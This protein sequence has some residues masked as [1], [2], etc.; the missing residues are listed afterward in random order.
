MFAELVLKDT[1][2]AL[3][4][5]LFAEM[6]PKEV[7]NVTDIG[8]K[9][10][11]ISKVGVIGGGLMGSGI[12]ISLIQNNISVV[13]KEIDSNFLQ[14]G[15]NLITGIYRILKLLGNFEY[16]VLIVLCFVG[17]LESLMKKGMIPEEKMSNALKLVKGT[18]DYSEFSDVDMVIEVKLPQ[19][20]SIHT[21]SVVMYAYA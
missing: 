7:P 12:A 2:K 18:L 11:Q 9:P 3:L 19:F 17:N 15:M 20:H 10:N 14:K 21:C 13:L 5:V 6:T 1:T 4:H 8:L 16:R